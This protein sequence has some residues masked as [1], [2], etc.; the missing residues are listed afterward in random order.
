M[1]CP[2]EIVKSQFI[3]N[4]LKIGTFQSKIDNIYNSYQHS[5][6]IY[7]VMQKETD[8][9]EFLQGVSFD[10]IDS[11]K[12]NGA[13]YILIFDDSFEEICNSKA[14]FVIATAGRHHGLS[15]L[16]IKHNLFD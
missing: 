11:V 12:N 4:W 8:N 2:S 15:T 5:Q 3:F 13:Q 10:Y 9:L 16:Y 7:D 1:V 6:S 14:F